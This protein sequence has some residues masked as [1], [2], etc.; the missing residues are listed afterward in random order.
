MGKVYKLSCA[1]SISSPIE[2]HA[3][4]GKD[5]QYTAELSGVVFCVVSG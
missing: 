1:V 4:T 3:P 2:S 5:A